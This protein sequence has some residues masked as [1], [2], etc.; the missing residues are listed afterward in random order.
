M[1]RKDASSINYKI[2][3]NQLS[4]R[5][6][7]QDLPQS[8]KAG[9]GYKIGINRVNQSISNPIEQTLSKSKNNLKYQ[10]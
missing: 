9:N 7:F 1:F 2:M 8:T 4:E 6:M 5:S 3:A 10:K